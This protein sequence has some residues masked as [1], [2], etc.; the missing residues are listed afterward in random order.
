MG[1]PESGITKIE[2]CVLCVLFAAAL[3]VMLV[4]SAIGKS[5]ALAVADRMQLRTHYEWLQL[6][7]RKHR[8][9]LPPHGGAKFVLSTWTANVFAHTPINL[10]R[11]FTPGI[12]EQDPDYRRAREAVQRGQDPWPILAETTTADTHYVG[13]AKQHLDT[14]EAPLEA[15]MATDNE[16]RWVFADRFVN[17]LYGD[18]QVACYSI[19][20]LRQRFGFDSGK[21]R[22]PVVTHGPASPIPACRKLDN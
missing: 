3:L 5:E 2:L 18:G 6:Y 1:H 12:R 7:K 13:R 14:A 4:P 19:D 8:D 20:R 15:W 21:V 17:V 10:D 11:F 22:G 16:G 9:A